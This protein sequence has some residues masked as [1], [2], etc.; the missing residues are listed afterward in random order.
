MMVTENLADVKR[1]VAQN[2]VVLVAVV[3]PDSDE[4]K[5]TLNILERIERS[6]RGKLM[7]VVACMKTLVKGDL[8]ISLFVNGSEVM[9]QKEL[10]GNEVKDYQVLKWSIDHILDGLNL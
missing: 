5:V 10:M 6:Y 7:S 4:G 8:A 9:R 2:G 3:D 1:A